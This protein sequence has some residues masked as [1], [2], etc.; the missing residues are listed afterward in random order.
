MDIKPEPEM[1]GDVKTGSSDREKLESKRFVDDA[2]RP[3]TSAL[4]VKKST[5]S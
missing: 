1:S 4:V 3:K 5:C 2:I